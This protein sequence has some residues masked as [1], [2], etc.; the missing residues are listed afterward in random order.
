MELL[1][2][3]K[4]FCREMQEVKKSLAAL[5]QAAATVAGIYAAVFTR[6]IKDE[7]YLDRWEDFDS[8]Q[9][10]PILKNNIM[11]EQAGS[12]RIHVCYAFPVKLVYYINGQPAYLNS[13]QDLTTECGYVFD[14]PLNPGDWLNLAVSFDDSESVTARCRFL[15]LQEV[16]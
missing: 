15:K 6:E 10:V 8:R 1:S 13:A 7:T 5:P 16:R 9:L 4:M 11:V 3:A 12:I 14:V 2:F